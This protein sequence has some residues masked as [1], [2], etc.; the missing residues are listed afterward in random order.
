MAIRSITTLLSWAFAPH[1]LLRGPLSS[2]TAQG[3]SVEGLEL[4]FIPVMLRRRCSIFSKV[5]L[6]VAH[7]ALRGVSNEGPIPTIFASTHGESLVTAELLGEL[8]RDQ[9]LSPMGFSLSVHNA[10]S[11]LFSIA[12][13]NTAPASAISSESDCL[14]MGLCEALTV[15]SQS[16]ARRVLL[17]CSDDIVA[18]EFRRADE[19]VTP[20]FALALLLGSSDQESDGCQ[21]L[22][23]RISKDENEVNDELPQGVVVARWLA[24][25]NEKLAL[26]ATHG[27]WLMSRS[28]R[29]L[30]TI[31]ASP[32]GS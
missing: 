8:A 28:E 30:S 4:G 3:F 20:P 18:K 11:G 12:T 29:D 16:E 17:V 1:E 26:K 2:E 27:Q 32:Q 14:M 5:T 23:E 24:S 13:G 31:F 21:L 25:N 6:A 22:F 9:Q 15:L 19:R 7:A 10:A